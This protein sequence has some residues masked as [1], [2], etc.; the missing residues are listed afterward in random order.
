MPDRN[1]IAPAIE[2]VELETETTILA[3]SAEDSRPEFGE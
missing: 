1:Y 3:A 2:T